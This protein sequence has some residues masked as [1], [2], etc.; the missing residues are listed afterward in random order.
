MRESE[1]GK[2]SI[3]DQNDGDGERKGIK[4]QVLQQIVIHSQGW[5]Y[6]HLT[7]EIWN[8]SGRGGN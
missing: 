1:S 2:R 5:L 7:T 8:L 4:Q 6:T 3:L